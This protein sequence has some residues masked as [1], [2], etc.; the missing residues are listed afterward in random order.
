[1]NWL[2]PFIR[3][4]VDGRTTIPHAWRRN[5]LDIGLR[6]G[7]RIIRNLSVRVGPALRRFRIR[8]GGIA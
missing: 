8:G 1:M 6:P 2:V 5:V 4:A 7:T 3:A